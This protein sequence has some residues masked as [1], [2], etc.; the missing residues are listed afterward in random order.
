MADVRKPPTNVI[1]A[2]KAA[3]ELSDSKS[4]YN[5]QR[6][7]LMAAAASSGGFAVGYNSG[8]VAPA[9]LYL[10]QAFDDIS[11]TSKA[12]RD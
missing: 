5:M 10:D 7:V 1:E 12:V 6:V 2:A 9:I 11:V 4:I 8:I 3:E